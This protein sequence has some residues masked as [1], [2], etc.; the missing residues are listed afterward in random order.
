MHRMSMISDPIMLALQAVYV[1]CI[2]YAIVS[3]FTRML[4]PNWIPL[5]LLA[6]FAVY[7]ALRLDLDSLYPHLIL[8]AA[9]FALGF[10]FFA[11]GWFGGGDVKLLTAVMIWMDYPTAPRFA[12]HMA[13]LG[14]ALALGQLSVKK[15]PDV[16]RAWAPRNWLINR[17]VDMAQSGRCP[18]GVA[19]GIA[20]LIPAAKTAWMLS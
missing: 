19:I 5:T 15:Y 14:G 13:V 3:D 17:L 10:V 1:F 6:A 11:L 18:Y 7:A 4:I 20:G 9:V 2:C 8:A 12:I 16:L